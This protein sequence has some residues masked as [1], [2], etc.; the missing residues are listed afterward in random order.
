M[1]V[2]GSPSEVVGDD[3]QHNM[4]TL[5]VQYCSFLWCMIYFMYITA[6]YNDCYVVLFDVISNIHLTVLDAI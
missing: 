5:F 4:K 2:K 3:D 6:H 1:V